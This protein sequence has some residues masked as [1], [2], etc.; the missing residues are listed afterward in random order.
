MKKRFITGLIDLADET[1]KKKVVHPSASIPSAPNPS[2]ANSNNRRS[3]VDFR[4][5]HMQMRHHDDSLQ[6]ASTPPA[7][8]IVRSQTRS[9]FDSHDELEERGSQHSHLLRNPSQLP[10]L[11]NAGGLSLILLVSYLQ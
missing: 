8:S 3:T 6:S 4:P 11:Q 1:S 5:P 10:L 9:S 7:S 2:D